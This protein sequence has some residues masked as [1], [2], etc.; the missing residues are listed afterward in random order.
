MS[1]KTTT[2]GLAAVAAAA[3]AVSKSEHDAA[4]ASARSAAE[5]AAAAAKADGEKSGAKAAQ[6][7]IKAI[8][9]SKEAKG[10]EDL[11]N[12][13]AFN[14]EMAA[15]DAI[16]TLS[17][18]PKAAEQ[19]PGSRLDALMQNE[20]PKVEVVESGKN[21]VVTGLSAAVT[22]QLAALGKEPRKVH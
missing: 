6:D 8:L 10:R 3:D 15:D 13:L 18:A 21:D 19:K 11:A 1:D 2:S 5:Q 16:V 20:Q 4:L 17:A 9:S 7:R 22:H 12:H 14:T